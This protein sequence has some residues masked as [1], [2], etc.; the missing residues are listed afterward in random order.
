MFASLLGYVA[1]CVNRNRK[2]SSWFWL[3]RAVQ[4]EEGP[5]TAGVGEPNG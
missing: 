4:E 5:E 3:D 2:L 1:N